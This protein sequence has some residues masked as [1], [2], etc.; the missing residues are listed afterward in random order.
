MLESPASTPGAA[1]LDGCV[2]RCAVSV[3][4][5]RSEYL[6]DQVLG[7]GEARPAERARVRMRWRAAVAW[8]VREMRLMAELSQEA[9]AKR[10]ATTRNA[11]ASMEGRRRAIQDGDVFMI[12]QACRVSFE[13][14]C[15]MILFRLSLTPHDCNGFPAVEVAAPGRDGNPMPLLSLPAAAAADVDESEQS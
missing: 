2:V 13:D 14:M 11:I 7:S 12:A 4:M 3:L 8:T 9:L 1:L 6:P 5:R 15:R 10:L